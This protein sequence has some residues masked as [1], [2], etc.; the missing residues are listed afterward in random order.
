MRLRSASVIG[1]TENENPLPEFAL[2]LSGSRSAS[3]SSGTRGPDPMVSVRGGA[4]DEIEP[5]PLVVSAEPTP[6]RGAVTARFGS[7][8]S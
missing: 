1:E 6:G 5:P 7:S 8:P 4:D 2:W 3:A